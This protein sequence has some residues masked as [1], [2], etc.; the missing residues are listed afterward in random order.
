ME[1]GGGGNEGNADCAWKCYE[2]HV[3]LIM[4]ITNVQ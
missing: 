2:T 4:V 1:M 3:L